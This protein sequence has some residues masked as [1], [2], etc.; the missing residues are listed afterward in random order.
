MIKV[1][2]EENRTWK[3]IIDINFERTTKK[4]YQ[5]AYIMETVKIRIKFRG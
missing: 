3:N 1:K 5:Y 4:I 2:N